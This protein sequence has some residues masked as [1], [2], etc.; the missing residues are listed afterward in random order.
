MNTKSALRNLLAATIIL[1]HGLAFAQSKITYDV[2]ALI[3]VADHL[4]VRGSTFQWHHPASGAAVGRPGGRNEPTR[5][6][7]PLD[8]VTNL[9]GFAWIPTWPE[10]PPAQIRYEASSST[11]IGVKPLLPAATMLVDVAVL[12]GRGSASIV[13]T[14]HASNGWTLVVRFADGA[15][16]SAFLTVRISIQIISLQLRAMDSS[17]IQ[18]RWPTNS[19][20]FELESTATLPALA[21]DWKI[22]TNKPVALGR[23]FIVT[24]DVTEPQRFFRLRRSSF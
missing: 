1:A 10:E 12:Q 4:I 20:G 6:S 14:P 13:Q 15:S 7:F 11:L 18:A 2:T 22:V 19:T 5:I 17:L 9:N 24:V 23:D 3:D 21:N 8:G 16:G